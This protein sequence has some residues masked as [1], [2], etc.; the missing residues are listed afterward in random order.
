MSQL[1]AE[2]DGILSWEDISISQIKIQISEEFGIG[3]RQRKRV[4]VTKDDAMDEV[5]EDAEIATTINAQKSFVLPQSKADDETG[6]IWHG[7]V[8]P[9]ARSKE[10]DVI[11]RADVVNNIQKRYGTLSGGGFYGKSLGNS[12]FRARSDLT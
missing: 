2:K 12:I 4:N 5:E 1:Q 7:S 9:L 11:T 8:C 10:V 6:G 3:P